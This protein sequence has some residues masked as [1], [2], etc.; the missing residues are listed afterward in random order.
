MVG[1]FRQLLTCYFVNIG[2]N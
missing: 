2:V 1:V